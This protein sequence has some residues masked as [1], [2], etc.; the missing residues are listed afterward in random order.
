MIKGER[1]PQRVVAVRC[2]AWPRDEHAGPDREA[3]GRMATGLAGEPDARAFDQVV[4]VVEQFCPRVEVLRP[5]ICAFDAKG[6]T[7]YFGGEAELARKVVQAVEGLGFECGA[8]IAD[9]MFAARLALR[10]GL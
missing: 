3:P 7:R 1:S 5:G 6:P 9:G 10:G 4:E 2:P 8:G